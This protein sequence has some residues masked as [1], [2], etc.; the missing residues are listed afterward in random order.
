M[1]IYARAK[2]SRACPVPSSEGAED[3]RRGMNW[4]GKFFSILLMVSIAGCGT[5]DYRN[6]A[7]LPAQNIDADPPHGKSRVVVFNATEPSWKTGAF[8]AIAV[9][10]NGQYAATLRES[11]YVQ[12]FLEPGEYAVKL[13]FSDTLTFTDRF[14]L[15]V[16]VDPLYVRITRESF[17]SDL[18]IVRQLPL[19]FSDNYTATLR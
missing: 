12:L 10:I 19:E 14:D 2:Q 8:A 9:E 13:E 7:V 16:G 18:E 17:A 11:S 4:F 6:R 3:F 1:N 5:M 15:K